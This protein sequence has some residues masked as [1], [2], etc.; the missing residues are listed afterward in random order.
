MGNFLGG[1]ERFTCSQMHSKQCGPFLMSS[2]SVKANILIRFTQSQFSEHGPWDKDNVW[3]W[4]KLETNLD[5]VDRN[6]NVNLLAY[7]EA[8]S[9]IF[10]WTS[11]KIE[12]E[13]LAS[14]RRQNFSLC[15]HLGHNW[16]LCFLVQTIMKIM[17]LITKPTYRRGSFLW[18]TWWILL[19]LDAA[20]HEGIR[21]LLLNHYCII[22]KISHSVEELLL[23]CS[24][25]DNSYV[26][27]I[28]RFMT[29]NNDEIFKLVFS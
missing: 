1:V 2:L 10:F 22:F 7:N 8:Y 20:S 19:C 9:Q 6:S 12:S 24:S 29:N 15:P 14:V 11:F 4:I 5:F 16:H 21:M 25:L 18:H 17:P 23:F 3:S 28:W 26:W 13:Y 27:V